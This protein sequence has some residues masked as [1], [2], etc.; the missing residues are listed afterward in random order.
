M[1]GGF[2]FN[3]VIT[4]AKDARTATTELN[5]TSTVNRYNLLPSTRRKVGLVQ[6][7]NNIGW[8]LRANIK[9]A[10]SMLLLR[11]GVRFANKA[12][13]ATFQDINKLVMVTYNSGG[14]GNY[15]NKESR[16][17]AGMTIL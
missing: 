10:F 14:D 5:N 16:L 2:C 11:K 17:R 13:I 4:V 1:Q 3:T 8:A 15:I 12:K 6:Q 9:R 7:G